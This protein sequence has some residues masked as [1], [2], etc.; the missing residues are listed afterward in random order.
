[1][2]GDHP[3]PV[4]S[5]KLLYSAI[6]LDT[7]H[8]IT[9]LTKTLRL[10]P[11][12][13]EL[14]VDLVVCPAMRVNTRS[15]GTCT[16][17]FKHNGPDTRGVSSASPGDIDGRWFVLDPK[18]G[19]H[20]KKRPPQAEDLPIYALAELFQCLSCLKFL[21]TG[22]F[23][24]STLMHALKTANFRKTLKNLYLSEIHLVQS[25]LPIVSLASA[26]F[27]PSLQLLDITE[28]NPSYQ[29]VDNQPAPASTLESNF[30][31]DNDLHSPR[32]KSTLDEQAYEAT[33]R[34]LS[35]QRHFWASENYVTWTIPNASAD[36]AVVGDRLR[37]L[38]LTVPAS[39]CGIVHRSMSRVLPHITS[40]YLGLQGEHSLITS[41]SHQAVR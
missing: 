7:A 10:Y 37:K 19:R 3:E 9:A 28:M 15:N 18:T 17:N 8:N 35:L 39:Y 24:W 21:N 14:C 33:W 4:V 12:L 6:V 1:M 38:D 11:Y 13:A 16:L 30:L 2:Q 41:T 5:R 32:S 31:P 34:T 20:I 40:M 36:L 22:G 27:L 29:P 23:T 26:D 25:N